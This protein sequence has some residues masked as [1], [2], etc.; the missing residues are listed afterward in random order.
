VVYATILDHI[1]SYHN[2]VEVIVV[3]QRF[4]N[5]L[6]LDVLGYCILG[7]LSGST[8]GVNRNRLKGMDHKHLVRKDLPHETGR[9]FVFFS[10]SSVYIS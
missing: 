2:M 9:Y 10:I 8:G 6:G 4:V 1:E 7:R 5:P 3:A